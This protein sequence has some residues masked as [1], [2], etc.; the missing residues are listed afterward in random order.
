[1][2]SS[3]EPIKVVHLQKIANQLILNG[4]FVMSKI[5]F[6]KARKIPLRKHETL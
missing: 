3:N 2:L 5:I 4:A 1:M 6:M